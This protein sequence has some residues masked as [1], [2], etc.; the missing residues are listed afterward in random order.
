MKVIPSI[1]LKDRKS[2][3]LVR[4]V[5]GTG[6]KIPDEPIKL[7]AYWEREG[8]EILHIIDLDGA[9]KQRET[10]KEIIKQIFREVSIPVEV[11]GGIRSKEDV[12]RILNLGARWVI[13]GT[14]AIENPEF[15]VE[16]LESTSSTNLI[17]ALDAKGGKIVTRG[18][19]VKTRLGI[20]EAIRKFDRFR[21][22]AY[23]CTNVAIEGTMTGIDFE[24]MERIVG[25]TETPIIYSGGVSSLKDLRV[26]KEVGVYA[27]V[28]GMAL[29][30]GVFTLREAQEVVQDA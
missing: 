16:L 2:V 30:K 13:M 8:A 9:I 29:Y 11:G 15:L 18:W 19:T 28:V 5:P 3:K 4:G 1:D 21:P 22:A 14:K 24:E 7:A 12:L 23:L 20:P 27:A 6:L 26:L 17:V 10:N 25:C